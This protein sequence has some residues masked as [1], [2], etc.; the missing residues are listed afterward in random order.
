V[1]DP[2]FG[3][4]RAPYAPISALRDFF[5]RI[6]GVGVPARVDRKFLQKLN[7][8]NSNEWSLLSALKFLGIVDAQ[9]IPTHSYRLLQNTDQFEDGL[10]HLVETAY[11]PLLGV[12]GSHMTA[13]D[14]ENYFRIASSP[15]QAKNAARFFREVCKMAQMNGRSMDDPA[16]TEK[17]PPD[18]LR[19]S[20]APEIFELS[21]HRQTR[22]REQLV[23]AR[24]RLL[25]K[26]PTMK[27]EW[28]SEECIG[29]CDR[30]LHMLKLLELENQGGF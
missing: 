11:K 5:E 24:L 26:F 18:A 2:D 22:F 10:L 1:Q 17:V 9:G 3:H 12:G 4:R 13:H 16:E 15:S 19:G 8:A 20:A 14:L 30:F 28:T 25:E 29:I 27:S 21:T 6:R 7:V 23:G